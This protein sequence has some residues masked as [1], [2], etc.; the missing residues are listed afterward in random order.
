MRPIAIAARCLT[1]AA[2][3]GVAA[4]PAHAQRDRSTPTERAD[5]PHIVTSDSVER[6]NPI[7]PLIMRRKEIG[8]PDSLIGR[9]GRILSQLDAKNAVALHQVDSLAQH[10]G[11]PP[12]ISDEARREGM[13]QPVG[14]IT[15]DFLIGQIQKNNDD[16]G[17][18]VLKLL[19]EKAADRALK[20]MNEQRQRLTKLLQ[21]SGVVGPGR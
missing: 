1:A 8:I 14:I 12:A 21:S 2:L 18:E 3:V 4:A 15:L 17:N 9:L 6:L 13:K 5:K 11:G 7:T 16:A 20:I 19:P 10:P